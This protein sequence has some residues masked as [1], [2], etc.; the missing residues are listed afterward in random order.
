MRRI[1]KF[2]QADGGTILLDEIGEMHPSIQAKLLRVLQEREIQ[3]IGGTSNISINVRVIASTNKDIQAAVK[4][5][6]FRE[7][8]F[9]RIAVFPIVIP[10]LR[11]HREDIPLLAEHFLKHA[12]ERNNKTITGISTGALQLLMGY[13]WPGNVRELE[14]VIER[15]ALFEESDVIQA[16]SLPPEIHSAYK[17]FHI[18]TSQ[19]E[20]SEAEAILPLEEVE[21]QAIIH[22]LKVT[23]NN[24]QQTAE[25][26]GIDRV[27]VYRK[28][29]KYNLPVT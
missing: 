9:Y 25:A 6:E 22:A 28:I 1:G 16:S 7:D 5:G 2:E 21:K 10:P 26:L 19:G 13:D 15:V 14:N 4:S 23:G 27:T 24:I 18:P 8:L 17:R 3:R 20:D 12:K 29:K 11:E